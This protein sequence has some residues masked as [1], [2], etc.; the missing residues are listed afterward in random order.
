MKFN[1]FLVLLFLSTA[2]WSQQQSI[3]FF[4]TNKNPKEIAVARA[5]ASKKGLKL[6]VYPSGSKEYKA[7][8]EEEVLALVQGH[9]IKSVVLSGHN[10]GTD[11]SG[12]LTQVSVGQ[13]L[14]VLEKSGNASEVDALYLLGCN[15]GNKSKL[16]FWKSAL[17]SLNF[18]AGYDG[19]APLG[20][21]QSGLDFFGDLLNKQEQLVKQTNAQELKRRLESVRSVNAG[22]TSI[23]TCTDNNEY[24]FMGKRKGSERFGVMNSKECTSKLSEFNTK[25]LPGVRE[26]WSGDKE[27]D[28]N[29]GKGFLYEAYVYFRQNEHCFGKGDG[30]M[31]FGDSHALDGDTLLQLRFNKDFNKNGLKYYGPIYQEA[32]GDM[33]EFLTD[34]QKFMARKS[35]EYQKAIE[36]IDKIL[37]D[38]ELKNKMSKFISET[39]REISRIKSHPV[40]QDCM[41][42]RGNIARCTQF[43][44]EFDRLNVLEEKVAK[45][46]SL[47]EDLKSAQEGRKTD[48]NQ[49]ANY[50]MSRHKS[51]VETA[52]F[53]ESL[54]VLR[55]ISGKPEEVTRKELN[56]L[57]HNLYKSMSGFSQAITKARRVSE[58]LFNMG[59]DYPFS[60]HEV[61]PLPIERPN[62]Y[63]TLE[64][65]QNSGV[66]TTLPEIT[67]VLKYME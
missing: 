32:L 11:Y 55:K 6:L 58:D 9:K 37:N 50:D 22:P 1:L 34:P 27:P 17:P 64:H 31:N 41:H 38:P 3:L 66:F 29:T 42:Q 16:L 59:P 33:E 30:L 49:M 39:N 57:A 62:E 36:D 28:H 44:K 52:E 43:E 19:T 25:F 24:L 13:V 26:Y 60:W 18:I 5:Q 15:T 35:V 14:S 51:D 8:N 4:D 23:L 40:I 2:A 20:H 46:D 53:Q 45:I 10:G 61:T 65:H 48:L 47:E 21:V 67:P 56:Y 54:K 12:D 63:V 7:F